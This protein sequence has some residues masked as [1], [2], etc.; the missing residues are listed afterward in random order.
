MSKRKIFITMFLLI[1]A[2]LIIT[3]AFADGAESPNFG[4]LTLLPAVL[5]IILAFTTKNVVLSLFIGIFTG[6][7]IINHGNA[8]QAFLRVCDTYILGEATDS[9]NAALVIFIFGI[10]G[11]IALMIKMGGMQA[12][13]EALSKKAD[14]AKGTLFITWLLCLIIFFED[15]ASNLIVGPTMRPL[16][17]KNRVSTEKLSFVL[18]S[19]SA[20]VSDIALISTWIA[21]EISMIK[22]S[23]ESLGVD[24]N[25]YE[26]FVKSVPYRFY[27]IL[28]IIFVLILIFMKRDYGPMYQAEI[29]ARKTGKIV[30]DE[31]R[32]MMTEDDDLVRPKEGAKLN[33]YNA[34][35]PILVLLFSIVGGLWYNGGGLNE[36]FTISGIRNAFGDADSSVVI[37]WSVLFTTVVTAIMAVAQKIVTFNEAIDI[38][39]SGAKGMF[40]TNTILILAWASGSVMGDLGT[41]DYIIGIV[42]DSIPAMLLPL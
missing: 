2:L 21:Y 18:D 10:G 20:P 38:W 34:I 31:G 12:I 17:E 26:L 36:S 11:L 42:G 40:L 28:A 19:T 25:A 39:L 15:I 41:A 22:I 5:I 4:I 27:N 1:A 9:W 33:P 7:V 13:A 14:S 23:F 8:F 16:A 37:L 6:T 35:I 29:R 30:V 32:P 3:P 24:V